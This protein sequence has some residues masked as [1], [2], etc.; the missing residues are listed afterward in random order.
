MQ[1]YRHSDPWTSQQKFARPKLRQVVLKIVRDYPGS[2]AGM[3]EEHGVKYGVS[4]LWKRISELHKE[5]YLEAGEPKRYMGTGKYQ[6]TWFIKERQLSLL[7]IGME[8]GDA[9]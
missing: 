7:E 4:G 3:I 8:V 2:T 9:N 5:N 1:T 6:R